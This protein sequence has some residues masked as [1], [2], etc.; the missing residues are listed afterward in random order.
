MASFS[1]RPYMD[2]VIPVA[3]RSV[4]GAAGKHV[5]SCFVQYAPYHLKDAVWDDR[6]RDALAMR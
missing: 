6:Q 1:R 3:D 2:I 5:M 4:G